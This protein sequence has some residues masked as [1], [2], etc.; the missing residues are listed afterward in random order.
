M[1]ERLPNYI[2][3]T[4]F[5]S[6]LAGLILGILL[7]I[8]AIQI[9][10]IFLFWFVGSMVIY[11]LKRNNFIG[12]FTQKEGIVVGCITGMLSIIAA[13]ASF[14]PVSLL[15]GAIFKTASVAFL[16]SS[17]FA[18]SIVSFAILIMIILFLGLINIIFNIAS[19]LAVITIYNNLIEEKQEDVNFKVEL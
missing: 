12:Q 18:S 13:S 8:P 3:P 9:L 4:I 7:F 15:V 2:K 5:L 19:A 10:A 16:F 14:I 17:T 1:L 11:L 6:V